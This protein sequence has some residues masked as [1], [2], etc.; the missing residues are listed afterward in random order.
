MITAGPASRMVTLLPRNSPT[1][2]APPIAIMVSCRWL[3][4]RCSPSIC[5]GDDDFSE[6]SVTC[7][8]VMAGHSRSK[9]H[10]VDVLLQNFH[11]RVDVVHRVV[12]V[13]RDAQTVVTVRGDNA[14]CR[15]LLY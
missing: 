13:K 11:H 10:E 1:P 8:L 12:N 2:M 14:V 15:Q 4:R 7:W 9:N 6:I 5:G 3:R